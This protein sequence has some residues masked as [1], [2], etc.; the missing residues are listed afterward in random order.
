VIA[1]ALNNE[2]MTP[3]VYR[4][5]YYLY[6]RIKLV[7]SAAVRMLKGST[8]RNDLA[9]KR[10]QEPDAMNAD[11]CIYVPIQVSI[12]PQDLT[13]QQCDVM[14]VTDSQ[15]ESFFAMNPEDPPGLAI[16][17]SGCTRT[18]HGT[19][20]ASKFEERLSE[21]NLQP[22]CKTKTQRFRGVGGETISRVVKIFPIGLGGVHGELHSAETDGDTPLL[23]SRPFMQSLGAIINLK[24]NVVSFEEI[25]VSDLPLVKTKRGH[26]AVS[27][28]DFDRNN[29]E[30]FQSLFNEFQDE[31]LGSPSCPIDT[32]EPQGLQTVPAVEETARDVLPLDQAATQGVL[33]GPPGSEM[34]PGVEETARDVLSW[35]ESPKSLPP[36]AACDSD[37]PYQSEP[38]D[39]Y[40]EGI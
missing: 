7:R 9:L 24:K 5:A 10:P 35:S 4:F 14:M 36:D 28:L 21:L 18:M 32:V 23:L 33:P 8:D 17:D 30:A 40:Y 3:E 13:V 38:W 12:N 22:M 34:V 19:V 6:Q 27:L 29:M 37:D 20:W 25:G 39:E 31:E 1:R 11:R 2:P 15:L 16:L 26:L